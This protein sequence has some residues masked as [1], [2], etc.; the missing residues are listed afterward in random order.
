MSKLKLHHENEIEGRYAKAPGAVSTDHDGHDLFT[1]QKVLDMKFL[2]GKKY[3][4]IEWAGYEAESIWEPASSI[5]KDAASQEVIKDFFK[6]LS[7]AEIWKS[8]ATA[9]GKSV[10]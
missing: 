9:A 1:M 10:M 3:Y 7:T 5:M 4:L 6:V 8:S 2:R